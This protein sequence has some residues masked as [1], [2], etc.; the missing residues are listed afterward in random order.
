M[1]PP[2]CR[3][4]TAQGEPL[5]PRSPDHLSFTVKRID[6]AKLGK[7][8]LLPSVPEH[9]GTLMHENGADI[10]LYPDPTL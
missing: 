6:A 9:H 5:Q 7:N 3:F 1:G 4:L 2:A 10:R 8:R